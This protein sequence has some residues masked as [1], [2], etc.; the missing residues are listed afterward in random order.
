M[1][2]GIILCRFTNI[3]VTNVVKFTNGFT[4]RDKT[5]KPA[6]PSA[7]PATSGGYF[8]VSR[9]VARAQALHRRARRNRVERFDAGAARPDCHL[10][11]YE[12]NCAACGAR[13]EVLVREAGEESRASCPACGSHRKERRLSTFATRAASNDA[14]TCAPAEAG[15]CPHNAAC[16]SHCPWEH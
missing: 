10:P 11:I 8:L 4:A 1:R 12:Y 2:A 14:P 15:A 7:A 13:F 6:A 5:R 16:G 3:N 9:P